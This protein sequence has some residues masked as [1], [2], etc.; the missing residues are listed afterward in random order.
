MQSSWIYAIIHLKDGEA[1]PV[2]ILE[3]KKLPKAE[4][5]FIRNLRSVLDE[6]DADDTLIAYE[7]IKEINIKNAYLDRVVRANPKAF[8]EVMRMT[9]EGKQLLMGFAEEFGWLEEVNKKKTREIARGLKHDNIPLHIIVK[10][11]GLTAQEIE[12][13]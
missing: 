5:L 12:E 11:T 6:N 1:Y 8:K 2:Q 3:S 4:N 13:L 9:A 7:D 10:N